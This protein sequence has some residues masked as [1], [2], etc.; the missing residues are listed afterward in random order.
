MIRAVLI[1]V[2]CCLSGVGCAGAT[3]AKESGIIVPLVALLVE[4]E[5]HD[6]MSVSTAGYLAPIFERPMLFL[7]REHWWMDDMRSAIP[8]LSTSL[9][10]CLDGHV[11]VHGTFFRRSPEEDYAIKDVYRVT[12]TTDARKVEVCFSEAARHRS[13]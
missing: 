10:D 9:E 8:V 11:E 1:V 13:R 6:G 7:T 2:V 5:A 3:D 4:P 12:R